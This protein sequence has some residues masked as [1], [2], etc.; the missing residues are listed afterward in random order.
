MKVH[1]VL[2]ACALS[3][4]SFIP[5]LASEAA[6]ERVRYDG[7]KVVRVNLETTRDLRTMLALSEDVWTHATPQVG[8]AADFMLDEEAMLA[9]ATT[10]LDFEVMIDDVQAL[11]DA[12]TARLTDR[13]AGVAG[14]DFYEDF[15]TYEQINGRLDMLEATRPDLAE[16][17]V[18]GQSLQGR[19]IRGIRI[20]GTGGDV[21]KPG[22]LFDG[23]QHARE[24]VAVMTPMYIATQARTGSV[25]RQ[26]APA[27][28]TR[29]L[30]V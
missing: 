15:R 22:V 8:M 1:S 26:S 25:R 30:A 28:S 13:G 11:I 23:C 5:A 19:D 6:P 17:F 12:E 14:Q 9:L 16:T 2:I 20:T 7:R 10:D 27:N 4:A 29:A 21:D 18:V 3:A 24:W